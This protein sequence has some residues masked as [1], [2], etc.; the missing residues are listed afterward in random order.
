LD[1]ERG[2]VVGP[3]RELPLSPELVLV[4][5]ELGEHALAKERNGRTSPAAALAPVLPAGAPP[6]PPPA[7]APPADAAPA[8]APSAEGPPDEAAPAPPTAA[9]I[10]PAPA[11]WRLTVGGAVV[12]LLGALA[13]LGG[14]FL[15]A[16]SV[17]SGSSTPSVEPAT[18]DAPPAE[19]A[20]A[21][22]TQPSRAPRAPV[23]AA[24]KPQQ[25]AQPRA[26]PKPGPKSTPAPTPKPASSAARARA[27]KPTPATVHPTSGGYVL[28]GGRFQVS[29]NRRTIVGFTLA[30]KCADQLTLPPIPIETTG[31]FTFAGH[32]AGAPS[33]TTVRVRGTFTSPTEARGKTQVLG[34][35]CSAPAT[36]FVAR[37]S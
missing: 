11:R 31:A 8:D 20:P 16:R 34:T 12:I 15:V 6:A 21:A 26:R 18:R 1:E 24:P 30:T 9:D 27:P 35:T 5:P 36:S 19:T 17:L 4:A 7:E 13:V 33:A 32:P 29:S 28:P 10:G 3:D 25:R 22:T 14:G 37:L 23:V 2:P